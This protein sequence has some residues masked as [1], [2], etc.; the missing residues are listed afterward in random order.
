M[1]YSIK[2]QLDTHYF[3]SG[4]G[5]EKRPVTSDSTMTKFAI[6]DHGFMSVQLNRDNLFNKLINY[7]GNVLYQTQIVKQ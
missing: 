7:N 3:V 5:S 6:S 4:V 2:N 1:I